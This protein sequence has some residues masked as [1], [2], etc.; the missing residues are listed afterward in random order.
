LLSGWLHRVVRL[1]STGHGFQPVFQGEA[2]LVARLVAGDLPLEPL[3]SL[4][5]KVQH[6]VRQ[7]E[8]LNLDKKQAIMEWIGR[9]AEIIRMKSA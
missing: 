3:L 7:I 5:E 9:L 6:Q 1:A 2:E 4:W 8:G